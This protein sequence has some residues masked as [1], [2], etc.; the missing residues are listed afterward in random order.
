MRLRVESNPN[1]RLTAILLSNSVLFER[2]IDKAL[3]RNRQ[4]FNFNVS[5]KLQNCIKK[6][7]NRK[8]E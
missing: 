4:G 6:E 8:T 3:S 7:I 5:F 2:F 1:I